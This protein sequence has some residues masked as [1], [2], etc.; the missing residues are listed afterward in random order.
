M[1]QSGLH[2]CLDVSSD[3]AED[4]RLGI[5]KLRK[6]ISEQRQLTNREQLL[7]D[8]SL[9]S[10]TRTI[11]HE[12]NF[13]Q[14]NTTATAATPE[15]IL[16]LDAV[17]IRSASRG[18]RS[19]TVSLL[20]EGNARD[21]SSRDECTLRSSEGALFPAG[22]AR[23]HS[24]TD[25]SPIKVDESEQEEEP[26]AQPLA[27][28]SS[29]EATLPISTPHPAMMSNLR[30]RQ[31]LSEAERC[32][33]KPSELRQ[34]A[35]EEFSSAAQCQ[36]VARPSKGVATKTVDPASLPTFT[37]QWLCSSSALLS[38]IHFYLLPPPRPALIL[39]TLS[40]RTAPRPS[41]EQR[42]ELAV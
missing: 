34:L 35:T 3:S 32:R 27:S 30:F 12:E 1:G 16:T 6:R 19:T 28:V 4:T 22:L 11:L 8:G 42:G 15:D 23:S 20:Q 7:V 39:P 25:D 33:V 29:V 26:R 10:S 13:Q 5:E 14:P 9:S 36:T 17:L 24:R 37:Q 2:G 18:T 38:A 41:R 21:G 31:L 40:L